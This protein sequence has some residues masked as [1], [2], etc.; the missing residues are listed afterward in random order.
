MDWFYYYF[1]IPQANKQNIITSQEINYINIQKYS[2]TREQYELNFLLHVTIRSSTFISN[3]QVDPQLYNS[4]KLPV[5]PFQKFMYKYTNIKK[6]MIYSGLLVL[7]PY[8]RIFKQKSLK[9]MEIMNQI[10]N[11]NSYFVRTF[12]EQN[13]N[14]RLENDIY[15]CIEIQYDGP[16]VENLYLLKQFNYKLIKE[17][18]IQNITFKY[19]HDIIFFNNTF[20]NFETRD[21]A[22]IN[23]L[24]ILLKFLVNLD[25]HLNDN[26]YLFITV[27]KSQ[28]Y[29]FIDVLQLL[30]YFFKNVIVIKTKLQSSLSHYKVI[31]CEYFN[32]DNHIKFNINDFVGTLFK[33]RSSAITDIVKDILEFDKKL[34]I[35]EY[36]DL[37]LIVNKFK[38]NIPFEIDI[39]NLQNDNKMFYINLYKYINFNIPYYV[40]FDER[41]LEDLF[42]SK[43]IQILYKYSTKKNINLIDISNIDYE[44]LNY[45]ERDLFN[46]KKY[47]DIIQSDEYTQLTNNIQISGTLKYK[48]KKLLQFQTSQ[49]FCKMVE[50]IVECKIF[51]KKKKITS[52]HICEAPGQFIQAFKFFC[53]KFNIDY[54]WYAN[55]LNPNNKVNINKY[56]DEIF[57]DSYSFIKNY[58][59]KWLYGKDNTGDIT[60]FE[61][62]LD[63]TKDKYDII[64]AD[65]GLKTET[66]GLQ[67]DQM[68]FINY[69]QCM[70]ILLGLK[71][72][73]IAIFKLFLP[74][75]RP[76]NIS[77]LYIFYKSFHEIIYFK[78]T[79][80]PSSSEIYVVCKGFSELKDYQILIDGYKQFDINKF[81]FNQI[82]N[83]FLKNHLDGIIKCVHNNKISIFR[84]IN[85][86][87]FKKLLDLNKLNK[88]KDDY[89]KKWIN[90]YISF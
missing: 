28:S 50:I 77:L 52:L 39:I 17:S 24:N 67:E 15:N 70:I 58:P 79:I 69:C 63:F 85:I 74:L 61:N 64:T 66:F 51:A 72:E 54:N 42:Y 88:Q 75:I 90:K 14:I 41:Q 1:E 86:F 9:V 36:T 11:S 47:L 6:I 87:Y 57:A 35:N 23:N 76:S 84:N 82:D 29:L 48:L 55:S 4:F 27:R 12:R 30:T 13:V 60:N 38:N 71:P 37:N 80:N 81:L 10:Q 56:G 25:L 31:V 2:Q 45:I 16:R 21:D 40:F 83:N 44:Y 73:G 5:N 68:A 22:E 62:I 33:T 46:Y 49:A 65:C 89:N 59:D 7:F 18:E 43:S 8:Y 26:G 34:V 78:P 3:I 32:I 20:F 19:K 53:K